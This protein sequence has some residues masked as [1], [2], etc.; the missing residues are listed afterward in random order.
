MYPY[1]WPYSLSKVLIF[2]SASI[3]IC[4]ISTTFCIRPRTQLDRH[5][6][7]TTYYHCYRHCHCHCHIQRLNASMPTHLHS[8]NFKIKLTHMPTNI[9]HLR[10]HAHHR[11]NLLKCIQMLCYGPTIIW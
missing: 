9:N 2:P 7:T 11:T 8:M 1:P 3:T 5:I 6:A 10:I 4:G